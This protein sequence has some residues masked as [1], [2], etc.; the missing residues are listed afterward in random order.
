MGP[1]VPRALLSIAVM[2]APAPRFWT[3]RMGQVSLTWSLAR[4]RPRAAEAGI[5]VGTSEAWHALLIEYLPFAIPLLNFRLSGLLSAFLDNAPT[6]LVFFDLAGIQPRAL[7][8]AQ[9]LALQ[10]ISAGA[11]FFGGRPISAM[12][13]T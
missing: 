13:R 2:P 5:G 9:A 1:A 4:L 12:R 10:A 11:A 8:G 3:R 7:T 6:Y